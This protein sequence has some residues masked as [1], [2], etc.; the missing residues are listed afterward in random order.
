M[1]TRD[2]R[3]GEFEQGPPPQ[4]RPLEVLCE[5]HNGTYVLPFA[6]RW[7]GGTWLNRL[8]AIEANVV[9]WRE[10]QSSS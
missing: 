2:H 5:D 3:L 8:R 6:C 10:L 4:D 1:V 9:G 7:S